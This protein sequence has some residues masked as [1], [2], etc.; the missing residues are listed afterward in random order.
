MRSRRTRYD[1]GGAR[2]LAEYVREHI[3]PELE[4]S[5]LHM[6][7]LG[8]AWVEECEGRLCRPIATSY[9]RLARASMVSP[10]RVRQYLTQLAKVGLIT[11]TPGDPA[12]RGTRPTVVRRLTLRELQ[13]AA[14]PDI[15]ARWR[16]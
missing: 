6:Y 11:W 5:P 14:P 1:H 10:S 3:R 7:F 12:G 4:A 13:A 8:I 9:R 15:P 16:M 2:R